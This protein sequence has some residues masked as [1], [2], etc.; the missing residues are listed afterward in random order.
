MSRACAG[1]STIS[2]VCSLA[3]PTCKR[4]TLFEKESCTGMRVSEQA[5]GRKWKSFLLVH[6]SVNSI[7]GLRAVITCF[8]RVSIAERK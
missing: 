6:L 3:P 7:S 8:G 4:N 2:T 1:G 5:G